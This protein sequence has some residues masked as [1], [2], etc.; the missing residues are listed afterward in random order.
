[1]TSCLPHSSQLAVVAPVI[2]LVIALVIVIVIERAGASDDD[3]DRLARKVKPQ[4]TVRPA[5]PGGASR[6]VHVRREVDDVAKF[7]LWLILLVLC[8]PLAVLALVLYPIV[9]LLLLP[10]RLIG[11]TVEAV[12]RFIKALFLLP[13][14]LLEA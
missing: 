10:F 6:V 5:N 12:L 3:E 1:M 13:A 14:R 2:A 4:W 9:W 7:I 8:W 11:I